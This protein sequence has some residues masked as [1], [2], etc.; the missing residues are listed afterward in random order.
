[1]DFYLDMKFKEK[2]KLIYRKWGVISLLINDLLMC[3]F[4]YSSE[5]KNENFVVSVAAFMAIII[6]TFL[7]SDSELFDKFQIVFEYISFLVFSVMIVYIVYTEAHLTGAIVVSVVTIIEILIALFVILRFAP[8]KKRTR[9][10]KKR[11][12]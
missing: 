12:S 10:K 6:C 2:I 11:S 3:I 1:M 9:K 8:L 5:L 7:M 4:I